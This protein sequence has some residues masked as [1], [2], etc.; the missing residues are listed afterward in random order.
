ME[1]NRF[2][3][4]IISIKPVFTLMEKEKTEVKLKIFPQLDNFILAGVMRLLGQ[5][6][7]RIDDIV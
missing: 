1:L 4:G 6:H 7:M 5:N 2:K 3:G